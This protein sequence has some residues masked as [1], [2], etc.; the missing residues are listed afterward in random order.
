M[1]LFLD[2]PSTPF[3]L[4]RA[5][6]EKTTFLIAGWVAGPSDQLP[7]DLRINGRRSR[8]QLFDRP[9]LHELKSSFPFVS[10]ICATGRLIDC[11]DPSEIRIDLSYGGEALTKKVA[12]PEGFRDEIAAESRLREKTRNWCRQRLRCPSCHANRLEFILPQAVCRD[13]G[14]LYLQD[15]KA[16]N[17]ISPELRLSSHIVDTDLV[18][19]NSYAPAALQLI[20]R[21]TSA[22]GSV[23]DCGAGF[24]PRRTRNVVNVEIV[25]YA[26][27]DVLAIG[28]A[29]PFQDAIFDVTLSLAVLEHVHDPFKC[30]DELI[31]VTKPGGYILMD[32]PFLQPEH[33]YPHHYYNM[34]QQGLA[35]LVE[36]KAK[37]IDISVPLHGH[38]IWALQWFLSSYHAGLPPE[39]R[40]QFADKT[41]RDLM[42]PIQG[43]D[44]LKPEFLSLAPETTKILACL[45]SMI[46]QKL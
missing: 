40:D 22:G 13:C 7:I 42:V 12:V 6:L 10:G 18:S 19:S 32:V 29:L 8:W 9:D 39:L 38:P 34:T 16:L 20:E 23:L 28:E 41:V 15:T 17:F 14:T 11:D 3:E 45:N 43:D 30:A 33:G 21:A 44:L 4:P 25:D 31:R 1:P 5:S 35:R 2:L 27:T 37:I 46:V 26:S 36:G 24:R